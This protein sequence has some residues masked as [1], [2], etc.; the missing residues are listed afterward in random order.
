MKLSSV[1]SAVTLL[2]V[3][4]LSST[5]FAASSTRL[6]SNKVAANCAVPNVASN[7]HTFYI[8]P[9]SGNDTGDG[10]QAHP[11]KTLQTVL[12]T[13]VSTQRYV[14]P[15]WNAAGAVVNAGKTTAF[16]ASAPIHAG[17][18]ILL[19]NGA[20][21][22]VWVSAVNSDFITVKA[23]PGQLPV[24]TSLS[25]ISSGKWV[26]SGLKIQHIN[27]RSLSMSGKDPS[28][29]NLVV[30]T[31]NGA[32]GE[33]GGVVGPS[34]DI[35]FSGNVLSS[36]DDT[37]SWSLND[38]KQKSSNGIRINGAPLSTGLGAS[39]VAITNNDISDV[40]FGI[41][42]A[43]S[44]TLVDNNRINH[45]NNDAIRIEAD[46][47]SVTNNVLTNAIS[48]DQSPYAFVNMFAS[49][50]DGTTAYERK[51][52]I[53][54][55]NTMIAQTDPSLKYASTIVAGVNSFTNDWSNLTF[56]NNIIIV[57]AKHA[58]TLF[59]VHGGTVSNNDVLDDGHPGGLQGLEFGS[60][61]HD[62]IKGRPSDG[63][64]TMSNN[65]ARDIRTMAPS[66]AGH[67]MNVTNNVIQDRWTIDDSGLYPNIVAQ[68]I[69]NPG[70]YPGNN[71]IDPKL[72]SYFTKFDTV[73]RIY[74]LHM[75]QP[76][77]SATA[78]SLGVQGAVLNVVP[79]HSTYHF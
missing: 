55:S 27:N 22:D 52:L 4:A 21:G 33:K 8:D 11:W 50:P 63:V 41:Q 73:N 72:N 30:I 56:T 45:F 61:G 9:V 3:I 54:D 36:A 71:T 25:V 16:N 17:D 43:G 37:S 31:S 10:S 38:W 47:I 62:R 78:T 58:V 60:T 66:L 67:T 48:Y 77:G 39:C 23:A 6:P 18:T 74:D 64:L 2:S 68:R 51:N 34:T 46:S 65:L 1:I 49:S 7:G 15:Y 28:N 19:M 29:G 24:L 70:V 53:V 69:N 75:K 5:A 44:N 57:P 14:A 35:I 40:N 13:K 79:T 26:F 32:A 12:N 20:Y 59:S 42:D 76:V